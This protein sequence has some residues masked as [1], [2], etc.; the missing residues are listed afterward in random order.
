[1]KAKVIFFDADGT[2]IKGDKMSQS[3]QNA[4]YPLKEEG[5]TLVLSTGRALPALGQA[6]KNIQFDNIISSGGNV[7]QADGKI[8]Y[9]V[10][11]SY[12]ELV[13]I[14]NYLDELE[15]PYHMEASDYIWLKAGEKK[16][17]LARHESLLSTKTNVTQQQ[18]EQELRNL[19]SVEE[20]TREMQDLSQ[21]KV[22]KI[23]YFHP[24]ITIEQIR[25]ELGD[26]FRYTP[27]SLSNVFSGG[28]ISR[29]GIDK[30][31]GMQKVL[32]HFGDSLDQV[33]AVGDDYNDIEM[34]IYSPYSIVLDHAPDEVKKYADFITKD[35]TNDGFS[36]AMQ[37]L[38]LI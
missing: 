37:S 24:T 20:R 2:I 26:C 10:H 8:I 13:E 35:I 34:L 3:T 27:L 29:L 32:E 30:K 25:N 28:E 22:N 18:Y 4:L 15:I 17:Y 23:H 5:H 6:L 33:I 36:Y 14:T 31:V 9:N 16:N 7:I 38:N 1:M 19:S 11:L 21:I 12:D